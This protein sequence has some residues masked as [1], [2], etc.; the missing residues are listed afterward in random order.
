MSSE[1]GK[2]IYNEEVRLYIRGELCKPLSGQTYPNYGPATG[3]VIGR[4]GNAG[5]PDAAAAV[6]A[7]RQAFDGSDWVTNPVFRAHCL[8]QFKTGLIA[9]RDSLRQQICG[10]TGAPMGIVRGPQCDG[11]IEMVDWCIGYLEQFEWER[12]IGTNTVMGIE[13]R[14]LVT[15]EPIGV[16][17]AITPWNFPLQVTLAKIIPALASGCT[18]VLKAAPET[19]WTASMLGR[20]AH[21]Y[22]DMP[23]GV[24][25]V[26]TAEDPA[27]LGDYLTGSDKIDMVSFTGS[28][29]VGKRVMARA[30][31][32]VKKVFLELG[33]KSA[34]IV[35]DDADLNNALTG[36]LAI[37]FHAGQGCAIASRLLVPSTK[38]Q[39]TEKLLIQLFGAIEYGNPT[40][41]QIMG[42]LVSEK[43][44]Q[45]VLSYIKT[46]QDEGAKLLVG[47][48]IPR[49]LEGGYYVEPTVFVGVDNQMRIAREEIF[50]P[51]LAVIYYDSEDDAVAIANDSEYGL[52]ASVWSGDQ[53]RALSVARKLRTG[54]VNI[55]GA[56]FFGP[57]A[58]FGGYKQSGIGR[59]M[60]QEG[61]E[62][63]LETK[64]IAIPVT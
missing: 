64:T 18:V 42:P 32:T 41:D 19:P 10:E 46:G 2:T 48:N 30:S 59:E 37:C 5:I 43:Q 55:N 27:V 11:P 61:F 56:N 6:E 38:K 13:S 22:T 29:A 52:S 40:S 8:K 60:G 47:G 9:E 39:E 51:V 53:E 49:H 44:R 34:Q 7:A 50:G 58:P 31:T 26:L 45:R 62:E 12:E 17:A 63:Y 4:A 54:T 21:D 35:L 23:A 57:D 1:I 24:L 20:I 15:K 16:V 33:G 3:T 36:S 25:N 14:R 28:T